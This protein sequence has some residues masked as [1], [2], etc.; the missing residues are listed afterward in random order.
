MKFLSILILVFLSAQEFFP[1][2][3]FTSSNLPI[4]VINTEGKT[5]LDE[6]KINAFMG[7]IFNGD[8]IINYITDP[9]NNYEGKIGIEIRGSSSQLFP[10][11]QYGFET[12]DDDGEDL[13]VSLLGFPEESDWI[14]SAPYSDKTLLRNVLTYKI[15]ND[16]GRYASRTKFCELVLNGE[17]MGVYILM[18]K[19]KR[20]KNRVN[21]KKLEAEDIAGD[22]LTGGYIIK[23]DKQ[24]GT[25]TGG[26][27]SPSWNYNN[28]NRK[29][30]YQYEY[31]SGDD[32]TTEQINYIQSFILNFET[33]LYGSGSDKPFGGYYDIIDIDSFIDFFIVNET[34]KNV[35]GYRLSTFLYKNR[36][37]EGGKLN[38]G[39]V[40]DFN[41]AYGNA[42]Y[43]DGWKTEGWE[44]FYD[45]NSYWRTPFWAMKLMDNSI[46]KNRFAKRW[47]ELRSTV[48]SSNYLNTFIDSTTSDFEQARIRNFE[49]WNVLDSAV[50]PN[51]FV[52]ETYEEEIDYLKDWLINRLNW[53][54][55]NVSQI[56]SSVEWKNE[57]EIYTE[58]KYSFSVNDFVSNINNVDSVTFFVNT[59]TA[60]IKTQND[61]IYITA[62]S[63]YEVLLRGIA[64]RDNKKVD[65]SPAYLIK[66]GITSVEEKT[67]TINSEY[68]LSQNYPNPFNP[69]TTISFTIPNVEDAN[70]APSTLKVFDVLGREVATLVNE[71]KSAGTY[72]VEFDASSAGG[73]LSSGI[74]FYT[75]TSG[76]FF[77]TKKMLLIK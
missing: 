43:D 46:F 17:Y 42:N 70:F 37:S 50:W 28:G 21:I 26:W 41:L 5:I 45:N 64:W 58:N 76:K 22:K 10:K 60:Q 34:A 71:Y 1:Q 33:V 63:D 61:S 35:D 36:E 39:P 52:G 3:N 11:K 4:V 18:E 20:D 38:L 16:L 55:E 13:D 67:N 31:P 27:N 29:V 51:Y 2:V 9:F 40:W 23:I 32:L 12:W 56:Y 14:L 30:Y 47:N 25:V 48:L 8:G 44:V 49:K 73:G 72:K 53:I 7:I 24:E 68:S 77:A 19:I 15:A 75:I 65:F 62:N 57:D 69:T 66:N 54:D 6:P 74:Y 59:S